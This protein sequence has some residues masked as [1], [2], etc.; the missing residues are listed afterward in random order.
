MQFEGS[1]FPLSF[2]VSAPP[3]ILAAALVELHGTSHFSKLFDGN[4]EVEERIFS[5]S[6]VWSSFTFLVGFLVVFRTSH[7]YNRFW[8]ACAS[9]HKMGA[10]W[11]D[12]C[13]AL[14]SYTKVSDA[15]KA[16]VLCFQNKV[17]RLFS[18]L[19]AVALA[20]LSDLDNGSE[21]QEIHNF[22]LELVDVGAFDDETL[23][24]IRDSVSRVEMVYQWIQSLITDAATRK[25]LQVPPPILTRSFQEL[26]GGMV[27]FHDAMKVADTPFPLPYKQ[28]CDILLFFLYV[29]SP[30]VASSYCTT[31][32]LACFF[33]FVTTFTFACL[34]LTGVELEFPYGK[35]ANDIQGKD[36]QLEMNHKLRL[37]V[38]RVGWN[39]P[40]LRTKSGD[41]ATG[42]QHQVDLMRSV[43][44]LGHEATQSLP[45]LWDKLQDGRKFGWTMSTVTRPSEI[46]QASSTSSNDE[47]N[48][49]PLCG[50]GNAKGRARKIRARRVRMDLLTSISFIA[51]AGDEGTYS[52]AHPWYTS[53]SDGDGGQGSGSVK[54]MAVH[55]G[56]PSFAA[57]G[58]RAKQEVDRP[59]AGGDLA[60]LVCNAAVPAET[61]AKEI[62][63]PG[64]GEAVKVQMRGH[65]F[66]H[67]PGKAVL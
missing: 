39:Q 66:S 46:S 24:A 48:S 56:S 27:C 54:E 34:W 16:D 32:W 64:R 62:P 44:N 23:A 50:G 49:N 1:V 10:E 11:F 14:I 7:A 59:D 21:E 57:G 51:P 3:A 67:T 4:D 22:E 63:L 13:S 25:I 36:L 37:L 42:Y 18:L 52:T 28:T 20:E 33:N 8:E 58:G 47:P 43:S 45:K 15:D 55:A 61:H 30:F 31:W 41:S 2:L 29:A 12:S 35:D 38:S 19:H 5:N 6:A 65:R 17:I 40:Q 9:V 60:S 53:A 26:S